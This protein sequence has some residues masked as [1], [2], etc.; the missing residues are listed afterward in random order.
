MVL[1]TEREKAQ[2]PE[3]VTVRPESPPVE[4][5]RVGAVIRPS[6]PTPVTPQD[7]NVASSA[8]Q[9]IPTLQTPADTTTL[10]GWSKGSIIN[11][12]TWFALFWLRMIKKAIHFGWKIVG[13]SNA[14]S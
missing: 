12:L 14:I 13:K 5:E 8:T 9:T 3:G 6:Q 1:F 2:V 10:T 7:A 11:S 4:I